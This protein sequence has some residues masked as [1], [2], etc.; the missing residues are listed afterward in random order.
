MTPSL[1]HWT[2]NTRPTGPEDHEPV[3]LCGAGVG[4]HH[5]AKEQHSP[6][7]SQVTCLNCLRSIITEFRKVVSGMVAARGEGEAWLRRFYL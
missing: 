3:C 6:D 5:V 2:R 7:I 4:I 1:I